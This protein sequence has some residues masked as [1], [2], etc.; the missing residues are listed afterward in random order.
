MFSFPRPRVTGFA[1]LY[2]VT[3]GA[4]LPGL[5]MAQPATESREALQAAI[6]QLL[7]EDQYSNAIWGVKVVDLSTSDV[8][9]ARHTN[10]SMMP[11]SNAKLYTTA[12]ALDQLGPDFQYETTLYS[13][14]NITDGIL[15]GNL[16]V[17]GSGDPTIGDRYSDDDPTLI[18]RNWAKALKD[19]GIK[20]IAGDI[21]GDDDLFDDLSLG[22]GWSWD[23]EPY[24][25]S[26]EISALTFYDNSIRF[27]IEGQQEGMPAK[28][29]WDPFNTSY[30]DVVN[31][32]MTVP[33]DSS[34]D[35]DYTRPRNFNTIEAISE[36][37]PA[38]IDTSYITVSNPTAYFT[39][40]LREVLIQ[41]GI[42]VLGRPVDVDELSI[43][44]SKKALNKLLSHHSPPLSEMIVILNK[45]SQNLYAELL[46]RTLGIHMPVPGLESDDSSAERGL[47]VANETHGRARV[48]T[49]RIKLLDGSGLSRMNLVTADM[50][51]N[52]LAYMWDHK[53]TRVQQAYYDSMPV[54]GVDG[55]LEDRFRRSPTY[56]NVRAKTGTLTGASALSG[57][58]SSAAGT[59][60][61]F[62]IMCN[63]YTVKTS[64]VR[65]TQN[66]LVTLLARYRQ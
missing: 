16:I 13:D 48:D 52:L 64:A 43:K 25:Y 57:Y 17:R 23:D 1:A 55:T 29:R 42:V 45:E 59:P 53:D 15:D 54:G 28:L 19:L 21:I 33:P 47:K 22:Y 49:S 7:N 63:N 6:H 66:A 11:A 36:I 40:V 24:Y 20:Q 37:Y 5:S 44:P 65:R 8:L 12:A 2:I 51:A 14:G 27:I 3:I 26:A 41:E 60:L 9:F 35:I 46:I 4:L 38:E 31:K 30:V 32:S 10:K 56:R 39:H 58:V 61:L 50:T 34:D 62:V 18:F